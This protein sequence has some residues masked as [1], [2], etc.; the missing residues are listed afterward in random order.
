MRVR[1]RRLETR[2][3]LPALRL[4]PRAADTGAPGAIRSRTVVVGSLTCSTAFVGG[5]HVHACDG[6]GVSWKARTHLAL[7]VLVSPCC[8]GPGDASGN[9]TTWWWGARGSGDQGLPRCFAGVRRPWKGTAVARS[10]GCEERKSAVVASPDPSRA[11]RGDW[12][13]AASRTD[14]DI[15]DLSARE[16]IA[17]QRT[18]IARSRNSPVWAI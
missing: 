4:D 3:T 12:K 8:A 11:R 6:R 5:D 7:V 1:T 9:R 15:T 13:R 18:A 14:Q 17:D 2:P 10:D 16:A